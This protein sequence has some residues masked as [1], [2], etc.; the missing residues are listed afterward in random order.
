MSKTSCCN[1]S[2]TASGACLSDDGA[3]RFRL[4]RKCGTGKM[5]GFVMLNPSIANAHM[6]DQTIRKCKGFARQNG[7]A[8]IEVVNLFPLVSTDPAALWDY[9]GSEHENANLRHIKALLAKHDTVLGFGDFSARAPR[10]QRVLQQLVTA[11]GGMTVYC[12][13]R[14]QRGFPKHPGRLGYAT[15]LEPMEAASLLE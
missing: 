6:D 5:L 3:F 8:G 12:L 11:I 7:Y 14:T 13:G 9:D 2:K 15:P 1:D 4:W 10:H